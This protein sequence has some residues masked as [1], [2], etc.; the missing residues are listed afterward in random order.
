MGAVPIVAFNPH[1]WPVR[2]VVEVEYSDLK[3]TDGLL[4]VTG[5]PVQFQEI[6]SHGSIPD[7]RSRL[8]FEADL[9]PLGY[10][11]YAMTADTPRPA[12]SALRATGATL[13]NDR[14]RIEFDEMNGRILSLVLR[15]GVR[16]S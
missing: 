1:P 3:A 2:S 9:P 14:I 4:D 16:T 10:Q 15:E 5:Q 13:E 11:T 7:W 12:Q 6:Q 8:A